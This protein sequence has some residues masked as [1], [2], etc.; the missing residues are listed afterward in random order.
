MAR[1]NL[2]NLWC[3]ELW[4]G[5]CGKIKFI[6]IIP[7]VRH[8]L[9]STSVLCNL[10]GFSSSWWLVHCFS[11]FSSSFSKPAYN[12]SCF[13]PWCSVSY[14]VHVFLLDAVW[15]NAT[16]SWYKWT[17]N[18]ECSSQLYG[19]KAYSSITRLFRSF[20]RQTCYTGCQIITTSV[21]TWNL[22][23]RYFTIRLIT[24]K[25]GDLLL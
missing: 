22:M 11:S 19:S 24:T 23:L 1:I 8:N 14:Q 9:A 25:I 12:I 20:L 16:N 21:K 2:R 7:S 5:C 4:H 3:P 18:K 6:I 13:G 17:M 10:S 15:K